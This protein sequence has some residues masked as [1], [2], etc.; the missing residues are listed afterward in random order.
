MA[1][2]LSSTV[3]APPPGIRSA[4][5]YPSSSLPGTTTWDALVG[6]TRLALSAGCAVVMCF[7][8]VDS[9]V[10][11]ADAGLLLLLALR[12]GLVIAA[13]VI[14]WSTLG[15]PA[16]ERL[17]FRLTLWQAGLVL[18]HVATAWL[19]PVELASH[20]A[21]LSILL[22]VY[23]LFPST[24]RQSLALGL[25]LTAIHLMPQFGNGA[26]PQMEVLLAGLAA[27]ATGYA[28]R[29]RE[30]Q[31]RA[32]AAAIDAA[33]ARTAAALVERDRLATDLDQ[34]REG[35]RA[36][37]AA[38]LRGLPTPMVVLE[39][40][41]RETGRSAGADDILSGLPAEA[42]GRWLRDLP[43]MGTVEQVLTPAAG[44]SRTL[45]A[46]I[47]TVTVGD[48]PLR[49]VALAE[50][51]RLRSTESALAEARRAVELTERRG[52][53]DQAEL[54]HEL[55][56]PLNGIFGFVQILDDTPL[57]PDQR[58]HVRRIMASA[59][60]MLRAIDA[61]LGVRPSSG[62]AT[63]AQA[64][65][66]LSVL[67]VEDDEVSAL[68]ART[69]LE[70]DGHRVTLAT[71]GRD[72]VAAA[73]KGGFDIILMDIRLPGFGGPAA[74]RRIRALPDPVAAAV[75]IVAMTA[76]VLPSQTARYKAAG[77]QTALA[78]PVDRDRLRAVLAEVVGKRAEPPPEQT[79]TPASTGAGTARPDLL[80]RPTLD[81]H[82][83]VLGPGRLAHVIESFLRAAPAT[84]ATVREAMA[85]RDL[86]ALAKSAHKLGSGALTVG[87]RPLGALCRETERLAEAGDDAGAIAGARDLDA[88]FGPSV[89]ALQHYLRTLVSTGA[90]GPAML[91]PTS[92]PSL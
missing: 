79:G 6:Q 84:L 43:A 7:T 71:N 63:P 68:L 46:R 3:S 89:E 66:A 27:N 20:V 75:P 26:W 33:E 56:T 36:E 86:N 64:K 44:P 85:D 5:T 32:L 60:D 73:A 80:D 51:T 87:L 70:R 62:S 25:A 17:R 18:Q 52:V 24:P 77:M 14:G 65:Q 21:A 53:A 30:L 61:H 8:V 1:P 2:V 12:L 50:A 82:L 10:L 23:L 69:L 29:V 83:G 90:D 58:D 91:Q 92:T 35:R 47:A 55:R 15:P 40:D 76:N 81:G 78:K 49:M 72:A 9:R 57:T 34:T 67:L 11:G 4:V 42:V 48:R 13:L 59:E 28:A 54:A 16:P 45:V 41:G 88:T 37:L 22:L 31:W 38:L 39:A 19:W 74:T